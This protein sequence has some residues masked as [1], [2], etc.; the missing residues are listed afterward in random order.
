VDDSDN[1]HLVGLDMIDD[2]IGPFQNFP[3]LRE[4]NF[5]DDATGLGERADLLGTSGEVV[6]DSQGV[7]W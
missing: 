6:N 4:I 1:V 7:L 5:R 2:S 3:Y